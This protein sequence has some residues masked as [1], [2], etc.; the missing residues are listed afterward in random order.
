MSAAHFSLGASAEKFWSRRFDATALLCWLSVVFLNF[1]F[2]F[3]DSP[4]PP[5]QPSHPMASNLD[6]ILGKL[7]MDPLCTVALAAA[8]KGC[9]DMGE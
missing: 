4:F 8:P 7:V 3:G 1:C 6:P 5:H 9:P 2:R